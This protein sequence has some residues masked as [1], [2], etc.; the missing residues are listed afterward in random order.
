MNTVAFFTTRPVTVVERLT[1]YWEMTKPRLS[2]LVLV[3]TGVGFVAASGGVV[4]GWLL[5]HTLIGTALVAGGAAVLNQYLE[6]DVDAL[7]SRTRHRPLPSGRVAPEEALAYGV[8]LAAAGLCYLTVGVSWLAGLLAGVSLATY[9]FCYTPM[10]RTTALCTLVGG[11][12][13]A[14]PPMI[15]WAAARG[16]LDAGAWALGALLF[17]WQ[18]P[19]F[20]AIACLYRED[21][22]RAGLPMLPVVDEDGAATGR[23]V[24]LYATALLPVSVLPLV[25]GLAGAGYGASALLLGAA[26]CVCAVR[27]AV[28][29]RS[30]PRARQLFLASVCYLPIVLLAL[31]CCPR[32]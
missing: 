27:L 25:L 6:R 21:Y 20:L 10:K 7:M 14:L 12:P 31:I 2:G 18:Q 16:T 24:V 1:A 5:L 32:P 13:G 11:I 4:D 15:G 23:Q 9:L 3:T 28:Q 30:L 26:F 8:L 19:H 22:A 29:P 17:L